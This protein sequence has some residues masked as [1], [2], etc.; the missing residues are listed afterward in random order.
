MLYGH[1]CFIKASMNCVWNVCEVFARKGAAEFWLQHVS[2]E[3]AAALF[4]IA[5]SSGYE[6]FVGQ[7]TYN[8]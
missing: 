1:V 4:K 3:M 5:P 2:M 8:T 6:K 7:S